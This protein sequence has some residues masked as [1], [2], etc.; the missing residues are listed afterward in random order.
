[1]QGL[2]SCQRGG[3]KMRRVFVAVLALILAVSLTT[4]AQSKATVDKTRVAHVKGVNLSGQVSKDGK[5]FLADDENTW[6]VSNSDLLKGFEGRNVTI[7]CRM[8]LNQRAIHILD[9]LERHLA[10]YKA[11]YKDNAFRR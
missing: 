3:S 7:K 4:I 8:D 1:M 11:S 10:K 2:V 9:V 5:M 6:S